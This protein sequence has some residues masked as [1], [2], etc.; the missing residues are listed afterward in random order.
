MA[1]TESF[2]GFDW[3]TGNR[4]KCRKHG[5]SLAQIESVFNDDRPVIVLP[6]VGHSSGEHRRRAIGQTGAGRYVFV[7]FTIRSKGGKRYIRPISARYMHPKEVEHYEEERYKDEDE[8]EED[9]HL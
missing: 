9:S 8:E 7:V 3:D 1:D 6:D 2:A 5:V 4:Q